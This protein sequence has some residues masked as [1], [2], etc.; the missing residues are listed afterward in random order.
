MVGVKPQ[1]WRLPV[2]TRLYAKATALRKNRLPQFLQP[3][4]RTLSL[5]SK[6]SSRSAALAPFRPQTLIT[7]QFVCTQLELVLPLALLPY[8]RHRFDLSTLV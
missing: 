2:L 5:V 7:M 4:C 8:P 1:L 6:F 3:G